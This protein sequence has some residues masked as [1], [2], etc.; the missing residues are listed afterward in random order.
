MEGTTHAS[1]G[2]GI[3]LLSALETIGPQQA[4]DGVVLSAGEPLTP[5]P[6][7]PPP[8]GLVAA[9]AG[10]GV[11]LYHQNTVIRQRIRAAAGSRS[12]L[13]AAGV[14]GAASLASLYFGTVMVKPRR[15]GGPLSEKEELFLTSSGSL[16]R[17]HT[18]EQRPDTGAGAPP[19][20]PLAAG[21]AHSDVPSPVR[22]YRSYMGHIP[23]HVLIC[24][25]SPLSDATAALLTP[26]SARGSPSPFRARLTHCRRCAHHPGANCPHHH[27]HG[28]AQPRPPQATYMGRRHGLCRG[29]G[30]APVPHE[31]LL[32]G[33]GG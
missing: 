21:A 6:P 13:T 7:S 11:W 9:G 16:V 29:S 3:H 10:F 4:D 25:S 8:A 26:A 22:D 32:G 30:P 20:C 1:D 31:G 17:R 18:L 14:V 2:Q 15:E 33:Q 12:V 5:W 24:A 23:G 27:Q 28:T 19:R